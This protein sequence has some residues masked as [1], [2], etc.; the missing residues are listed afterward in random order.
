MEFVAATNNAGKLKE[1]ERILTRAGHTCKSLQEINLEVDVEENGASFAEN[2]CI[3]AREICRLCGKPTIADDSGLEVDFLNGE[4]GIF[5]ARYCGVHGNDEANNDKLLQ[6]LQGVPKQQRGA[7]FVSAVCV[8]L[9]GGRYLTA[10]GACNG[11]IGF[12]RRGTNGFGYDPIFYPTY[13]GTPGITCWGEGVFSNTEDKSYAE[14]SAE[15]KDAISHRAAAMQAL[16]R[17]LD[18]FLTDESRRSVV[19]PFCAAHVNGK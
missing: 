6:N 7:R 17:E 9:P 13:V 12:E 11:Y 8:Y 5:T 18:G 3:K 16:S 14:L 15:Q 1:I 19:L 10:M 2:A 4:P